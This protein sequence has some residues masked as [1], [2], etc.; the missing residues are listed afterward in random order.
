M[1]MKFPLILCALL[2]LGSSAQT[3]DSS[4][5]VLPAPA[6]GAAPPPP[7]PASS[8]IV[9]SGIPSGQVPAPGDIP[10][11]ILAV[12]AV[13]SPSVAASGAAPALASGKIRH[14]LLV[15]DE[16]IEVSVGEKVATI[17]TFPAPVQSV[18]G[19]GIT[20]DNDHT[21]SFFFTTQED[22]NLLS[23]SALV[24]TPEFKRMADTYM[25]VFVGDIPYVLHL[26]R[27]ASPTVLLRLG[28]GNP[29]VIDPKEVT[30]S[31][32]VARRL[33]QSHDKLLSLLRLARSY[34][35]FKAT[36]WFENSRHKRLAA[37][38]DYGNLVAEVTEVVTFPKDDAVVVFGTLQNKSA[39]NKFYD[40]TG[41]HVKVGNRDYPAKI[42]DASGRADANSTVPVA[43]LIQGGATGERSFLS[44][45][46][47]F[48]LVLP[49]FT[50]SPASGP[51]M[52]TEDARPSK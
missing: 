35:S 47:D 43:V 29:K 25:T 41:V 23:I 26:V 7:A 40:P 30:P 24:E 49:E 50:D 33:N 1:S 36:S 5:V 27:S 44:V 8:S 46:N 14:G 42:V 11:S 15:E 38:T 45:D 20:S 4:A 52:L 19:Y 9:V 31:D 17:V 6:G 18:L 3:P 48:R 34:E 22:M 10:L 12:P 37:K 13:A 28:D 21:A 39:S 32:V 16:I 2:A 51:P